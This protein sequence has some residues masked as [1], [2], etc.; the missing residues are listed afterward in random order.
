[1]PKIIAKGATRSF[2]RR[3]AKIMYMYYVYLLKLK[4]NK[5]YTGSTPNLKERLREHEEGKCNSTRNLRPIKLLWY[6][7]F[8]NR[9][10]GR[11]FESYLKKG[12]R[13][14]FRNKHFLN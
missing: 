2:M 7:A 4:N 6:C 10:T 13:Q 9:L 8:L 14:A 5:I 11:R 3:V 12:S 1:V